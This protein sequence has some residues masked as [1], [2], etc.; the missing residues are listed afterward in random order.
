M[1]AN[2]YIG[3]ALGQTLTVVV[4]TAMATNYGM[5]LVTQNADESFTESAKS[6]RRSTLI[7]SWSGN[8]YTVDFSP[9][10][11]AISHMRASA[12]RRQHQYYYYLASGETEEVYDYTDTYTTTTYAPPFVGALVI[13]TTIT[14][15][16]VLSVDLP[17]SGTSEQ[18]EQ[19]RS[20][21][22]NYDYHDIVTYSDITIDIFLVPRSYSHLPIRNSAGTGLLRGSNGL[23]LVDA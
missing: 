3:G 14:P 13:D 12:T 22:Y 23:P 19:Y 8:T 6:G 2:I 11:A 18:I 21:S 7:S 10:G 16:K 1:T 20:S 17:A 15:K 4:G 9:V 5:L